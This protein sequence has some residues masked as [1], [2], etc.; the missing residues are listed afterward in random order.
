M[1]FTNAI[2]NIFLHKRQVFLYRFIKNKSWIPGIGHTY[3]TLSKLKPWPRK[4]TKLFPQ[5]FYKV[6]DE[7][8][9]QFTN[10]EQ[11]FFKKRSTNHQD[12]RTENYDSLETI[13]R[14][15]ASGD[16]TK[17][18]EF[19]ESIQP[20]AFRISETLNQRDNDLIVE[21]FKALLKTNQIE[22]LLKLKRFSK[23]LNLSS[24][25]KTKEFRLRLEDNKDQP[26]R[27]SLK[28]MHRLSYFLYD[29][30]KY[31]ISILLCIS[32]VSL[33]IER[34]AEN[35]SQGLGFAVGRKVNPVT[36]IKET[37]DDVKGCDEV[38]QE[39]QEI[40]EYLSDPKKF[41]RL[42][43]RLPKGILL[44]GEPGTGKT[45]LARSIAGEAKVPFIQA[46]ATEFEEMFVGVGAR[47]IRELFESAHK[48]AP[49]I[50]F[51]DEIDAVG[52]RREAKDSSSARMTLNQL[53][54]ELDGF[55]QNAG[56]VV[57][58]A[59]NSPESLDPALTRPG[60]LDKTI[61]VPLPDLQ[62]RLE[63]LNHF[64]KSVVLSEDANMKSLARLTVGMTG[65]D[66]SN[67]INIAA[68]RSAASNEKCISMKSLESALDRV[69]VGLE[70]RNPMSLDERKLTSIHEAGH[71]I[72]GWF[73][74]GA[75]PVYKAT[76]MPR[77]ASLGI[78][79][80]ME[81]SRDRSLPKKIV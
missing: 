40:L 77:G 39:L 44:A 58:C 50:I 36:D 13:R 63:I 81:R 34:V 10:V 62:G 78:K 37:L 67:V 76:I 53:L 68:V 11:D 38:K 2:C 21:Y 33:V 52:S 66:L 29:L 5:K 59:T 41:E 55:R 24:G 46:S 64:A 31:S 3:K 65:A 54:V 9:N 42:G 57:I 75:D 51:I 69:V 80:D 73:T 12:T 35:L 60:R 45:L 7:I 56:I 16:Y 22:K 18:I 48:I 8:G 1:V 49:V 4:T 27:V 30:L 32:A 47:R 6:H 79:T 23:D 28:P 14:Y 43:A 17:A 61:H 25:T 71:A 74:P 70:R 20:N 72:A 15:N 19:F 26:L